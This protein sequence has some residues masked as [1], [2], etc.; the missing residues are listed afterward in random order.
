LDLRAS[1]LDTVMGFVNSALN[2]QLL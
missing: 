1:E 2:P